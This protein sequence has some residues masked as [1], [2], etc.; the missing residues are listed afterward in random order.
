MDIQD[1][2]RALSQVHLSSRITEASHVVIVAPSSPSRASMFSMCFLDND[3]D[4]GLLMYS[5]G[6][7]DGVTLDDAYTDEM[8]M[9]GIG[10]ILDATPHRPHFAFDLFGVSMLE[11]D[12]DD[13]ITDVAIPSFISV[14]GA[15]DLM[16]PPLFFFSLCPGLSPAMM[17]CL[18][19]II[20]I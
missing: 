13:F 6:G 8:D 18:M 1:I 16:D 10:H 14:E 19:E 12:G 3:F 4:Y 15:S 5:G 11:M 9:I 2:Q 20:T 17:L 7:P